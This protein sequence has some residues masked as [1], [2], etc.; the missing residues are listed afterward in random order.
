VGLDK[1]RSKEGKQV[2]EARNRSKKQKQGNMRKNLFLRGVAVM[3]GVLLLLGLCW[4][5]EFQ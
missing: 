3:K 2:T 5:D 4:N 1:N